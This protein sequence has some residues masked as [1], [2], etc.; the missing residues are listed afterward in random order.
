MHH[1]KV[2]AVDIQILKILQTHGRTKRNELAE[3]VK[4]SIPAVSERLRKLEERGIIRSY[5]TVLDARKLGIGLTAFIFVTTESSSHYKQVIEKALAHPEILECHAVTGEGS[6]ILK[7]K[8]LSTET[9]EKL[10]SHIQSWPGVVTTRTNVVLSS[11]KEDT[12]ISLAHLEG[13]PA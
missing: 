3:Q 2:D 1:D 10:I 12:V 5:N 4:L 9:L 11:P 7:I 8:T 6:H 13:P